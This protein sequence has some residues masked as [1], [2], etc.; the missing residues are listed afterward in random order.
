M[1]LQLG[2]VPVDVVSFS[3]ALLAIEALVE[4]KRGGYV[5]TP[6]IDHVVTAE[7]N[8]EFAKAYA[9]ASLSLADGMPIVWGSRLL[10]TPLPERVAG[11]DLVG[12]LLE[13]AGQKQWR[14]AFFGAGP[15]VADK[16]AAVA[17]EKWNTQ[18][19]F[20]DAPLVTLADTAQIDAIASKLA[21]ARP[22]LILMALG[23]PKQE[24]LIAAIAGRVKPAVLLGIGASLDFIAGTVKR[25]PALMRKT[26]LEWLYRL[27]Q[28]PR[29]LWRRYLINDPRFALI[30]LRSIRR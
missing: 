2:K 13:L 6:N 17:K 11:S 28:E 14:V 18:V 22:D 12:P 24:L 25:A 23:A 7:D 4:G 30:L 26:G 3:Q 9:E 15:G 8:A 5:F 10:G 29:R 1:R 21:A 20:T 19:I 27:A 16:A